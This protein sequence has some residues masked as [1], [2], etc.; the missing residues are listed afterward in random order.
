MEVIRLVRHEPREPSEVQWNPSRPSNLSPAGELDAVVHLAGENIAAKRWTSQR[1]D[2]LRASRVDVTRNLVQSFLTLP[3]PPTVFVTAS[4]T[5]WYR[6]DISD[7]QNESA[8]AADT[9]LGRLVRDWE[10]AAFEA[11]TLG[12]RTVATR[13]GVVLAKE[14]GMFA[15]LLPIFRLGLGGPVGAGEQILSWVTLEDAVAAIRFVLETPMDGPVNVVAPQPV[16]QR[17]FA[18]ALARALHRPAWIR[19][20]AWALRILFGEMAD[21]LLLSG[22]RVIPTRLQAAGFEF[23]HPTLE[24]ALRAILP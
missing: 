6:T 20:P 1:R 14:G 11:R 24:Q 12:I 7:P 16:P 22:A 2:Q 18:A 5:G 3:R 8:P 10:A 15:R 9:F 19:T 23:Q 17:E 13:F 21:A 4:A